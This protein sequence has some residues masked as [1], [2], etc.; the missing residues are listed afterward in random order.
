MIHVSFTA[1]EINKLRFEKNNHLHPRVRQKM[2]AVYLKALGF[3]HKEICRICNIS[4]TTLGRYL[5]TYLKHGIEGLKVFCVQKPRSKLHAYRTSIE[6]EFR[7]RPP[8]TVGEAVVRIERLTGIKLG[9]TQVRKFLRRIGMKPLVVASM[10][11][12]SDPV[13]Q[14][15]F[16]KTKLEPILEE[17][18]QGLRH[19]F[20]VDASHFIWGL[21]LGILWCFERVFVPTPSGRNRFNVLGA[22]N[23]ITHDII[24]VV[25]DSYINGKSIIDLLRKLRALYPDKPITLVL[26]NAP[27]QK[28]AEVR[29]VAESL[30]IDLLYLPPYSPNLNL[31]ERL[32]K[33]VK[34]NCLNSKYH[35]TFNEFKTVIMD[36][37]TNTDKQHRQELASLLSFNFQMFPKLEIPKPPKKDKRSR[38]SMKRAV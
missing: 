26:D 11:A 31:I 37:L 34:K 35:T 4:P 19:V 9:Y 15:V 16:L 27:Y 33:Y 21:F 14:E 28:S 22:L 5:A 1:E 2:E 8:A 29:K 32:W 18:K 36:C 24:T 6:E 3:S 17:S 23:A 12:K 13:A 25:N 10:P 38:K 20:F 7:L 30:N